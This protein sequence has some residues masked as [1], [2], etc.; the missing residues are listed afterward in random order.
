MSE[1]TTRRLTP[2]LWP[3]VEQLFGASGA[4]GG[5]WCMWWRVPRG[6]KLW[7]ATQGMPAKRSLAR[8]VAS[9]QA[10][11]MLAFA[12]ELPIGWCAY[13]PRDE[14][15]R[16]DRVRAYQRPD[17][18]PVWSIP[19]FFIPA[20]HRRRGVARRLLAAVV[21]ECRAAGARTLE[22]YPVTTTRDGRLLAAAFA[23]TGPLKIFVEQGFRVVR[24]EPKTKPLVRLD[25]EPTDAPSR[26]RKG[27]QRMADIPPAVR[28]ALNAGREPTITLVEWLAIDIRKLVRAIAAEVG[29]AHRLAELQAAARRLAS[30]GVAA[31][32]RGMGAA[33]FAMLDA[34]PR[35]EAIFAALASHRAD[36]VRAWAAYVVAADPSLSL[37]R[38]LAASRP[39]AA[40]PHMAVRECAWESLRAHVAHDPARGLLLERGCAIPTPTCAAAPSRR[41]GRAASGARTSR[42]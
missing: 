25:L 10:R 15:P 8:L 6:G 36:M 17:A 38:R 42:R 27:A 7:Q 21:N 23:F 16:L 31:R 30:S 37:E 20:R 40:D 34:D 12:G 18:A 33:L 13:G 3:A 41:H 4:C 39:F 2:S 26:R 11:A 14:F 35:R 1:I 29:L 9:G 19:C 32:A 28:R 22:A 5:C 24:A